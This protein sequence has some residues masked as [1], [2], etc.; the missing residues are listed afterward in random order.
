MTDEPP[1]VQHPRE[2]DEYFFAEGCHIL[3]T[4]NQASDPAVSI[5]RARV[6]PGVTTRLHRLL[7]TTE[8]YLILRGSGLVQVGER[9]P[10]VVRSGDLVY[11]PPGC[12]QCMTNTELEDLVFLAVCTPRFTLSAY[13]DMDPES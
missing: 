8:R 11:I 9:P 6:A 7:G 13:D 1:L 3:E 10:E 12:P 2:A 5:A 4:W